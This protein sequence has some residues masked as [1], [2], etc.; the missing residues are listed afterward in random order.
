M[1][2][3]TFYGMVIPEKSKGGVTGRKRASEESGVSQ[4]SCSSS[5]TVS[6]AARGRLSLEVTATAT[7]QSASPRQAGSL[8][9]IQLH[10]AQKGLGKARVS[11]PGARELAEGGLREP[12]AEVLRP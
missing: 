5:S 12:F 11:L 4:A 6:T 10:P 8:P 7:H 1:P 3:R 9:A 2:S